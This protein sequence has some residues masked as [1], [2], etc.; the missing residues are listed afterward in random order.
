MFKSPI[1]AAV[2]CVLLSA[3]AATIDAPEAD[4]A[5]KAS[6]QAMQLTYPDSPRGDT[7]DQY[8]EVSVAD[9]YRW[10]EELD[11]PQ[12][13]TWI[14]GQNKVTE[15]VLST[16]P[17]RATFQQRLTELF[18]YERFSIPFNESGR[19]F[20]SKNDGLQNQS[21]L[22]TLKNLD[23]EP[24]VLLDPN[25]L[26]KDGTL[27]L[28][29]ISVSP[30]GKYLA[31]SVSSGG[32][33]WQT[34]KIR[35]IDS[36]VDLP[37]TVTWGKFSGASWAHDSSGFYY[38]GFDE[39][40]GENK[41]KATNTFQKV[42]FYTLG[43]GKNQGQLVFEQPEHPNQGANIFVTDD[44]AYLVNS[45]S[46]GTDERNQ[47]YV[48][49]P[50]DKNWI[51][52]IDRFEA[53]Y[54]YI[55]NIGS[56]FYL[57]TTNG[58]PKYRVIAV[59]IQKPQQENW[60]TVIKESD[61][62]LQGVSLVGN[63]LIANYLR[64]ARGEVK[65][66]SLQGELLADIKLPGVGAVG[67]FGGKVDSKE[68]FYAFS[69]FTTASEIFRLDLSN[70]QSESYRKPSLKVDASQFETVQVFYPSKDGTKIPMFL[71][72]KKGLAKDGKAPV[73]LYGYGGF[74]IPVTPSFSTAA[75]AWAEQG[76]IWA[77][78]NLRG[79]GEYGEA[80]HAAGT[81][82]QKQNVFDDFAAAADY[83]IAENYTSPKRIAIN[84]RSNGGLLV[85]AVMLQRPEL[86]GAAIPGVGVLDMLR[87]N[88]FTIGKAWESD[89]GSPQDPAQFKAIYAYSPLHN[90][91]ANVEYPATLILT[92]DHDDRVYP[93][94]S[95]KF[96]AALQHA[97]TGA[98]PQL[99]RIETRG[100]HGAGKPT[101]MVIS[102]NADWLAFAHHFSTGGTAR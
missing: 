11:S 78:A 21:V 66:F 43:S 98:S 1:S 15:S 77:V 55:G 80:W 58:A 14:E 42:Y 23:D 28:S 35:D 59:D 34:W 63:S 94:H 51:K 96:A 31:Y 68:T 30:N 33:D 82:L 25:L 5:T 64:D 65:R 39:P 100:G 22:Y 67:G 16:L 88:Q 13:R 7:K 71:T 101:A 48:K 92:G 17:Q 32:S 38:G 75:I 54:N 3:C 37:D 81:K 27:A 52:L 19:W 60:R 79:G 4:S 53:S 20:F 56:T 83:L 49:K 18:N 61:A 87:F 86:F 8:G 69:S 9:P 70:N 89:Y 6:A 76:G 97:Y 85:A 50:A 44:G 74:N 26:S 24:R 36:G 45:I 99:I 57:Q 46:L 90:I 41:L 91:Q 47:L 40:K 10:L 84:G 2:L 72:Y 95:F 102:E 93:A 29:G 62:T 12:T 73:L